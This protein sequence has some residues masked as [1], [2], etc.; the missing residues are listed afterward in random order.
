MSFSKWEVTISTPVLGDDFST[1]VGSATTFSDAI[2]AALEAY[3]ED[4]PD[5]LRTT[6][7]E[8]S[9]ATITARRKS[10]KDES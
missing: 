10:I 5:P 2:E 4:T 6:L 1:M 9:I 3:M 8:V 7:K